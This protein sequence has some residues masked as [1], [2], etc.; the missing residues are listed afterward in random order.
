MSAKNERTDTTRNDSAPD[1]TEPAAPRHSRRRLFAVVGVTGALIVAAGIVS[2]SYLSSAGHATTTPQNCAAKPSSCGF[3]DDTNTGV[4][5]G[6]TLKM[7]PGQVSSGPGWHYDPRGW[8]TVDGKGAALSGLYI[9]H[10]VDVTAS[11]VTINNVQVVNSGPSSFGISLRH[12]S[13]VTIEN[14]TVRGTNATTGRVANAIDDLYGDST[15]MVIK[16]NNISN[17]RTGV[18]VSS[19]LVTGNY[20]HNP[21]YL[22][23]DHNNG[24]YNTGSTQP[25]TISG[26]TIFNN[27]GQTDDI[28]LEASTGGKTIANKT[29]QN[30]LLAGGGYSIYGGAS[31]GNTTAKIV[32]QNNRFSNLYFARGGLYGPGAYFDHN[33]KQNVWSGNVWDA[34]GKA[35]PSP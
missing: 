17:W 35:V 2:V 15:G 4:P 33:G 8:V 7:V 25:L 14:S 18:Q 26:N 19:G 21:G 9:P 16:N 34:T 23:G 24:I 27:I 29:I 28:T 6:M 10:N 31:Q 11:N 30:N 13:N 3:P 1:D 22:A 20:I 32:I 5:S 12:T